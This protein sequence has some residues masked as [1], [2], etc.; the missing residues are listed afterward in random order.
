MIDGMIDFRMSSR[1]IYNLTRALTKPYIGAHINYKGN[2]I[3]VW[4][5]KENNINKTNIEPGKIL[6][7]SKNTFIVKTFDGCIEVLDH[8][9]EFLPKVGEY[10]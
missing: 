5:V 9:F 4:K 3:R 1:A 6:K 2:K 10:L 7:V 8:E